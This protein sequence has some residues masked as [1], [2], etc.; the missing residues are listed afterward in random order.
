MI[1][2]IYLAKRVP[3]RRTPKKKVCKNSQ[4]SGQKEKKIR[5]RAFFSL[6]FSI[7]GVDTGNE[8]YA[9]LQPY[10]AHPAGLFHLQLQP[11]CKIFIKEDWYGKP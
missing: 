6:S 8:G 1:G 5:L 10:S 11:L 4:N 3:V 9:A 7:D 2:A